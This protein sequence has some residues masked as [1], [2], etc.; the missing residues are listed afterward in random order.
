MQNFSLKTGEN[1]LD[2]TA[3][4]MENFTDEKLYEL[5]RTYGERAL[6]WRRKFIGLLPE[7]ARRELYLKKNCGS[8]CEFAAKLAGV[9]EEHVRLVLNLEKRFDML[10]I[11]RNML[12]NGEVSVN[13]LARIVSVVTPEDEDFWATQV[14]ILSQSA[15]ETLV[16]DEK[17]AKAEINDAGAHDDLQENL[18]IEEPLRAQ[19]YPQQNLQNARGGDNGLFEGLHKHDRLKISPELNLSAEV[20]QKLLELQQKGIDIN[21]LLLE[22]LEK[23][24]LGIAQKKEKLSAEAKPTESRHMLVAVQAV[25]EEEH[26]EKCSIKTCPKLA[27]V[28]HHEQRFAL[29]KIHD[30]K[31]LAPLCKEHHQIAHSIDL[32]YYEARLAKK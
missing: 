3:H 2:A 12:L 1:S 8:I 17:F 15:L 6:L 10:P 9:S 11:L 5:C 27:E 22:F 13:K 16:R 25:L 4:I 21:T 14:K 26:G 28:I 31:Y 19:T 20:E 7:V 18:F 23:R 24:E 30:P 29:S 32:K